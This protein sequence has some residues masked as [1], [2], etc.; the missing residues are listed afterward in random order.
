MAHIITFKTT[1]KNLEFAL[2]GSENLIVT[3]GDDTSDNK[4]L[5]GYTN[6]TLRHEFVDSLAS[7]TIKIEGKVTYLNCNSNDITSL[8]VSGNTILTNLSCY[9]NKLTSLNV[10]NLIELR[11]LDCSNN[12]LTSLNVSNLK[13]LQNL[14]C[15]ENPL[16]SLNVSN[17]KE[18]GSLYCSNNQLTSLNVSNLKE[19]LYFNCDKNNMNANAL[20]N[21]FNSLNSTRI[22]A[23]EH[24]MF[25]DK[26]LNITDNPGSKTCNTKIATQK[27]WFVYDGN[28]CYKGEYVNE[29][30]SSA[31]NPKPQIPKSSNLQESLYNKLTYA[32]KP[33]LAANLSNAFSLL[34]KNIQDKKLKVSERISKD[35]LKLAKKYFYLKGLKEP[36][37]EKEEFFNEW[38]TKF[39]IDIYDKWFNSEMVEQLL[40]LFDKQQETSS[41]LIPIKGISKI[42]QAKLR[43]LSIYDTVS[44]LTKGKTQTLRNILALS[45]DVDVKLVNSWVKQADLW[46]VAGMT[47]DT[48]Y[49]LVQIGVRHAED[50]SKISIDKAYPIMERLVLTQPDFHLMDREQFS[51]L[52]QKAEDFTNYSIDQTKLIDLLTEQMQ[53]ASMSK[54]D[55]EKIE[56]EIISILN[57]SKN[58]ISLNIESPEEPP[59]F[60]FNEK[61][62]NTLLKSGGRIIEEGLDFLKDI[63]LTLPL[64]H[65]ISGTIYMKEESDSFPPVTAESPFADALVEISGISSPSEDKTEEEHNPSGYTDS[66][67]KFTIVLPDK[68]NLKEL[69]TITV[70]QGSNSQKFIKNASDVIDSVAEQQTLKLFNDL[71]TTDYYIKKNES[72]LYNLDL[73]QGIFESTDGITTK[74]GK[75]LDLSTIDEKDSIF[76]KIYSEGYSVDEIL[77]MWSELKELAEN[78]EKIKTEKTGWKTEYEK[79]E[80]AILAT[81]STTTILETILSNLMYND[82]LD[83]K[84][85]DFVLIPSVFDG[86]QRYSKKALPSV[87]LMGDENTGVLRLST[88]TAPS[89]VFNYGMLQRL[90]EPAIDPPAANGKSRVTLT[91][92]V[93][94]MDFKARMY[95]D[96]DSIP[97][98]ASL[99][100]GYILNMHQAWVPDGFA[101]GSLL[102]SVVLAP[103]EEQRLIVREHGQQYSIADDM[104]GSDA[105]NENY[106]M[107]QIDDA[108]ATFNYAANQMSNGNSGYEYGANSNSS[109]K[110]SSNTTNTTTTPNNNS[111]G[112]FDGS[113]FGGVM[114]VFSSGL[115]GGLIGGAMKKN[116]SPSE[117]VTTQT[118]SN[119]TSSSSSSNSSGSGS[120]FANQNNA[121]NELSNAAQSFQHSIQSASNK[122]SQSKR[123]S[124]RTATSHESDSVATKII[125]NH[126]HSHAMTIQ[127]WEVMRRYKLETCIDGVELM[128]F[129]PLKPI[130][131]LPA[132]ETYLRDLSGFDRSVFNKRYNVLLQYADT[133]LYALPY[134]YRTG[135][136]LIKK[137]AAYPAWSLAQDV[138]CQTLTLTF[139]CD[140]LACDNLKVYT[141]LKNGKGT[142]AGRVS[143]NKDTVLADSQ[144]G[145]TNKLKEFLNDLRN[146]DNNTN[147]TKV[148]CTFQIP[149]GVSNDDISY[150]KIDYICGNLEYKLYQ[151]EADEATYTAYTDRITAL[152]TQLSNSEYMQYSSKTAGYYFSMKAERDMW[153]AMIPESFRTPTI[154]LSAQTLM[155]IGSPSIENESINMNTGTLSAMLS[156][157]SLRSSVTISVK[158]V[159]PTLKYAELQEMEALMHH[160]AAET[161][162]YSQVIWASLSEDEMAMM[163]ERYT[164][165]MDFGK[166]QNKPNDETADNTDTTLRNIRLDKL[167]G[168]N[169]NTVDIPL[170]NCVNVKKR[171][172]FYGNCVLLPFTY[173][174]E[175]SEKLGKTAAELQESLY[176]YHT[177]CFRVPTTTISLPTDGMIGEAVL[178]ETNVSELIDITRFWN[179]KDSPIDKM[180]IDSNYLNSSDYLAGKAPGEITALNL[181][182]A[183][184]ATPVTV[185]DLITALANKQAPTFD[186]LTA[187]EQLKDIINKGSDSAST[188]RDKVLESNTDLMK[189]LLEL[190]Y[191]AKAAE[192]NKKEEEPE[193]NSNSSGGGMLGGLGGMLGGIGNHGGGSGIGSHGSGSNGM[194]G[195]M[196]GDIVGGITD[197]MPGPSD[198]H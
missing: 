185:Q 165:D 88:D 118:S 97:K 70:S 86:Y 83:S 48:A 184:A 170:L 192:N 164:I 69:V 65:T 61:Y 82:K 52:I 24:D 60:L 163:L 171:V 27:G 75:K 183:T 115:I 73:L 154:T 79:I 155:S 2:G 172:G 132:G 63:V 176:R 129:V 28:T 149:A 195:G 100:I 91:N 168:E 124:V 142:I 180:N 66:E 198:I 43:N 186:N 4:D 50:L 146:N 109:S 130:R 81:D 193:P 175:L 92:P 110:S 196:L 29:T 15:C 35:E 131:F 49:L 53:K 120:S 143:Y 54:M 107:S 111:G 95:N 123:I 45:L 105:T 187:L 159:S 119:D 40:K 9:G 34:K 126:N 148:T 116:S 59:L 55:T 128:L 33:F 16:T 19:L 30:Q 68:Y 138:S 41:S 6:A 189:T 85:G 44:L 141:V 99:G 197:A 167:K 64:P 177:N 191:A 74:D 17:L 157:N 174:Q 39:S 12:Q 150:I 62:K 112:L 96:P 190:E 136:N 173:P 93:D 90:V 144:C 117:N 31:S 103:G 121:Y 188:G 77:D 13:E 14:N 94:V 122:I 5:A 46:R 42:M 67:G 71:Q 161:L 76:Y 22:N 51:E 38:N 151:S 156:S 3:W 98:M 23:E 80:T 36:N 114:K 194:G 56:Q 26:T 113:L 153:K 106:N 152:N 133:L 140:L 78:K 179:W 102:Y 72:K 181:Q 169:R 87:K 178:G 182:G 134:Q 160:V 25:P 162:L 8:D 58:S 21:L 37:K 20:N 47:T 135:L 145:T 101:L 18:L 158:S 10:S 11:D 89:R 104:A 1:K 108:T 147:K 7:H 125:A 166:I 137:Y 139:D 57:K 127:Y 84:L 32:I